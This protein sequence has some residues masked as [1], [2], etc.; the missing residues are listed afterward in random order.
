MTAS[1][2]V[3]LSFDSLIAGVALGPLVS[4]RDRWTMAILFGLLDGV[5]T[6]VSGLRLPHLAAGVPGLV[7]AL[8][9]AYGVYL[10]TVSVWSL[11]R[12]RVPLWAIPVLLSIDNL[13]VGLPAGATAL[14]AGDVAAAA[15]TSA[16]FALA[17]LWAGNLLAAA[18]G[19]RRERLAG[20]G[21]LV[22]A[23]AAALLA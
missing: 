1:W 21:L 14:G 5:A 16:A 8:I 22:V 11:N 7:P 18:I 20:A 15:L 19:G 9:A 17:G 10:I 4:A 13:M 2:A 12:V 6:L 3:L 23:A